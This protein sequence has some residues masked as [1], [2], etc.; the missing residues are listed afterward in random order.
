MFR[1]SSLV[2]TIDAD[3]AEIERRVQAL[4]K[5]VASAAS[6][7]RAKLSSSVSGVSQTTDQIADVLASALTDVADR[8]RGRARSMGDEAARV[9][10][11]AVRWSNDAL[12]RI[13][14]QVERRPFMLLAVAVGIGFLIGAA[15]RRR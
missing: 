12:R 10:T 6:A 4:E 7:G 9:G 5:R 11:E 3:L 14:D 1:K 8:F 2:R 15:G 13:A